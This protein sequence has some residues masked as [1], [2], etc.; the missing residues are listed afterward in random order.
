M[1]F[2]YLAP[3]P[4]DFT[5]EKLPRI[6]IF[7]SLISSEDLTGVIVSSEDNGTILTVTSE[8]FDFGIIDTIVFEFDRSTGIITIN[9]E[10]PYVFGMSGGTM[11]ACTD[12]EFDALIADHNSEYGDP[13]ST[14]DDGRLVR[15]VYPLDGYNLVV[16]YDT[17]QHM[18]AETYEHS[19][20]LDN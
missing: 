14:E 19:E 8:K 1:L 16:I 3:Y 17:E 6:N 5:D 10:C 9:Y 18:V 12:D 2:S 13:I 7:E 11:G 15:V 4:L 20:Y